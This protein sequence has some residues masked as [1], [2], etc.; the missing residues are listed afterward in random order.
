MCA[1]QKRLDGYMVIL[2]EGFDPWV[3]D[4]LDE[5]DVNPVFDEESSYGDDKLVGYFKRFRYMSNTESDKIQQHLNPFPSSVDMVVRLGEYFNGK[6]SE[7]DRIAANLWKPFYLYNI[8]NDKMKYHI[9]VVHGVLIKKKRPIVPTELLSLAVLNMI[10][11]RMMRSNTSSYFKTKHLV[12]V[13]PGHR[14][15]STKYLKKCGY[16]VECGNCWK[17]TGKCFNQR[18]FWPGERKKER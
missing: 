17:R 3:Y 15:V 4:D 2:D 10:D 12:G 18:D 6:K 1:Y 14:T 11:K 16:I 7:A 9:D 13:S 8:D 5:V